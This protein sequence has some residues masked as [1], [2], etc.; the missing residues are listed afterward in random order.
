MSVQ[1]FALSATSCPAGQLHVLPRALSAPRW[2][3]AMSVQISPW[4]GH[5][6]RAQA[7]YSMQATVVAFQLPLEQPRI[8]F[9]CCPT[10]QVTAHTAPLATS[11]DGSSQHPVADDENWM[12]VELQPGGS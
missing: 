7:S 2:A 9:G 4:L 11:T 3:A 1:L 8:W 6:W 12:S 5:G 10:G